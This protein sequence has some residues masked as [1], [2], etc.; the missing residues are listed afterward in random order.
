MRYA[1][2][3]ATQLIANPTKSLSNRTATPAWSQ[4]KLCETVYDGRLRRVGNDH[5]KIN[6][7][8]DATGGR[9]ES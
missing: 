4:A 1:E 3:T 6:V 8:I 9:E 5:V 7:H 2:H